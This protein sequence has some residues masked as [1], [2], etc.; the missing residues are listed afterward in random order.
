MRARGWSVGVL[1][2]GVVAT[3]CSGEDIAERIAEN[4]IEA[5]GGGDVDIDVDDGDISVRSEDGSFSIRTDDD[6][7][8]AI[9]GVDES[10]GETF[11]VES[12]NGATVVETEDGTATFSQGT[13]LPDGFPAEVALPADAVVD[14]AQTSVTPDGTAYTVLASTAMDPDELTARLVAGLVDGGLTQQQ[15]VESPD[16][17]V[18]LFSGEGFDV[19]FGVSRDGD[20]SSLQ[21]LVVPPNS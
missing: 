14:F 21:I 2:F 13:E 7:N 17:S 11:T 3:G 12:A 8:V 15:L 9:D 18:G 16:G 20:L 4:R 1:A 5:E 10:G 6:G 19:S